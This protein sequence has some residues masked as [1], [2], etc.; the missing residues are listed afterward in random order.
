ME[1]ATKNKEEMPQQPQG[2]G[3]RTLFKRDKKCFYC[4]CETVLPLKGIV[5]AHKP[6][7]ATVDHFV[8][9]KRGG[10]N[11]PSNKVLACFTCNSDKFHLTYEE[12]M[13][14]LAV[15]TRKQNN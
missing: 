2:V 15:R 10:T 5:C 9:I 13:A 14:V 12:Y 4:G 8:P 1:I 7:T 11:D 3:L 6:N